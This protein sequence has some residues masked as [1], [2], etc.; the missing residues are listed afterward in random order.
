MLSPAPTRSTSAPVATR[1]IS[2]VAIA[3]LT[4]YPG[5][6]QAQPDVLTEQLLFEAVPLPDDG[7]APVRALV[8]FSDAEARIP[9]PAAEQPELSD[10]EQDAL[11]RD[12]AAYR[13]RVGDAEV[14]EGP[15]SDQLR[16]DLF[17]MGL[18][19]QRLDEHE[20][21]LLVMERAL[22]VSRINYGLE[23]LD[24][25]PIMEAMAQSYLAQGKLSD[26][27][28]MMEAALMLQTKA[29][30]G[31]AQQLVPALLKLGKWNT[32]AFME[33]SSI[34]VNIPRM[35]VQN[36][37]Q[38]PKGFIQPLTDIRD[39]PLFKLY[40]ARRNY[41]TALQ[42]LIEARNFTHP[43]LLPLE[44]E[45]LTNYFLYTHRENI[46]YE[47]DF[48]L[49]RR[50]SKTSS[51]LNQNS[52]E[53]LNS[54]S[55]DL[56]AEAHQR[57]ISYIFNDPAAKPVQ[58]AT[59]ML[60]EAD[61]DLLYERKPQAVDKYDAAYRF[62]DANPELGQQVQAIL[63]PP[64]PVVLPTYLPPPNSRE[65]LGIAVDADVSFF[66]YIDVRFSLTKFGKARGIRQIGKGGEVTRNM[67]IRLNQYLRKVQF[68]PRYTGTE[69]DTGELHLRYYV[70][71]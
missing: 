39:T 61:W 38:D 29:Y 2:L 22:A 50:K 48:Y 66:G 52:I 13:A 12:I 64:V 51:R 47:P 35:N 69:V 8:S 53:L 30:E 65:K 6:T 57:I 19:Y 55:Y 23:G 11:R 46:L 31:D 71:I 15:Y 18:M 44:R 67:E 26:A 1:C 56:G 14:T 60:E 24:Q 16:E 7:A 54:E 20:E 25:V 62:F 9:I 45:L 37:L 27:D 63:Y 68:R 49:T 41:L 36:F 70:G 4:V 43:Y 5:L 21:A 28:A 40:E 3:A 10:A 59:A 34:L 17:N 33:R 32:D 58:L 42:T